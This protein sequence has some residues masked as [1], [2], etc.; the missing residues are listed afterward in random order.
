[1][2]SSVTGAELALL[3]DVGSAWS[4]AGV[5]GRSRGAWRLVAHAA[6]P[7]AW[8]AR[9]LHRALVDQLEASGDRRLSGRF[10]DL[11]RG[12][13]RIECHSPQR[14]GRLAIVAVSR[15]LSG[16]AARR[17]AESAG[18]QTGPLVSL[19]DG[20]SLAERLR[21]LQLAEVDAWLAVGGFDEGASPRAL[22]CA[23]IL[24]AARRP[25]SAPV[26][27]AGSARLAEEVV[28]LFEEGAATSVPNARPDA[29]R[30]EAGPLRA[31]LE[32]LLRSLL[33][34]DETS[35]LA[36]VT[37]PRAVGALATESA[38]GI[39]AVDIGARSAVRVLA[40][41][42]GQTTVRVSAS[43][44]LSGVVLVPGAAGRVVRL[45][46]EVGD[47]GTVAD[48]LQTQRAHPAT[49]PY[50]A[51]ELAAI[52]AATRVAI[53]ALLEDASP[54]PVDLLVGCGRS[55][56]AAPRPAEA[57]RMLL[58]GARPIGV[59][60]VAVDAAGVLG[61]LGSLEGDELRE[62]LRLL[63]DDL[64]VPLGTAVVTRGGEPGQLAMRVTVHRAGW[65][66]PAPIAVRVGQVQVVA[67]PRGSEAELS[68]EPGPGVSLGASRRSPRVR[69]MASGGAVGLVLDGRGIPIATPRR[70]DDRRAMQAAWADAIAR[71]ERTG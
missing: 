53:A 14:Q 20:R 24:A 13:N 23:A 36:P 63:A 10:D 33:V 45:A 37:L 59:T 62:G 35:H 43:G 49:L 57:M 2:T 25:G 41:P 70:G 60:Q 38:L 51:E 44:G 54:G 52:Q 31:H 27:W 58:D 17:A 61:P 11:L 48:V 15:E 28:G 32:E 30:D 42:A 46:G 18:W 68:I 64:L 47:E 66:T 67:L 16:G 4:K 56:A 26:I 6:Q 3:V 12:A 40:T 21:V 71:E 9:E 5:I 69:A 65:P 39:L 8:G 50:L 1:M 55:L 34:D 19:D 22:E 7:T 29:R